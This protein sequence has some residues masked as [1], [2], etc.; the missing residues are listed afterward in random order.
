MRHEVWLKREMALWAREGL[1]DEATL[2]R[3]AARYEARGR[4]EGLSVGQII[5]SALGALLIGLGVIALLAHNWQAFGR[6]MR[7]VLSFLPLALCAGGYLY[8]Q[9]T[10][11]PLGRG[12]HEALG[13]LWS[14][15]VGA[16]IALVA[17]TYHISGD[18]QR[19]VLAWGVLTLPVLYGTR[20]FGSILIYFILMVVWTALEQENGGIGCLFWLLA[21]PAVPLLVAEGRNPTAPVRQAWLGWTLGITL[22]TAVGIAMERCLPGLWI[23]VYTGL[24][25]TL[26]YLGLAREEDEGRSL[27]MRPDL[28]LGALGLWVLAFVLTFHECWREAFQTGFYRNDWRY[29]AWAGWAHDV[30]LAVA[31]PLASVVAA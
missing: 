21:L 4:R 30:T 3:I 13:I 10:R 7:T 28:T 27:F 14:C 19:F 18:P 2:S 5:F 29:H 6:P 23:A 16:S 20:A 12:Y 15:A 1:A 9:L 24:F 17:Q 25:A 22:L 8:G 31:A 11:K 26:F